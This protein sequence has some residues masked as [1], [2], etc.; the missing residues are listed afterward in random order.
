M[1]RAGFTWWNSEDKSDIIP[2]EHLE[3]LTSY[4]IERSKKMMKEGFSWG[5]LE[6]EIVDKN[7]PNAVWKYEGT[8]TEIHDIAI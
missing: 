2:E 5:K 8:W 6:T 1:R 4:A 3:K 7:F